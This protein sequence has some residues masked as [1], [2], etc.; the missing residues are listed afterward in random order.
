MSEPS[1]L[2]RIAV[3]E[4]IYKY[5]ECIDRLEFDGL[6]STMHDELKARF[7]DAPWI[8]GGDNVLAHIRNSICDLPWQHHLLSVYRVNIAEDD[9]IALVYHTSYQAIV[10]RPDAAGLLV[11]RY[12]LKLSRTVDGWKLRELTLE[13]VWGEER[14]DATG[15]LQV[16]MGGRGPTIG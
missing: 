14:I 16:T 2:D 7:G 8:E 9:A 10:G 3:T 5:A 11:G 6:R 13:V 15:Y 4:T 12:H 1:V